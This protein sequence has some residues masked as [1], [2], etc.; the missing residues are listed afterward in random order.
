MRPASLR[1]VLVALVLATSTAASADVLELV[2]G[3]VVAGK[4]DAIDEDGVTFVPEKGGSMRVRWDRVPHQTRYDLTRATLAADDAQGRV[5][6]ARWCASVGLYRAARREL[7]EAKGLGSPEGTDV[8]ALLAEVR[9]AEADATLEAVDALADRGDL[10]V[11]L[12][13]LK[14]Y[15]RSADP[16]PDAD[17]VRSRVADVLQRIERRDEEARQGEE[18]RKKA[19]KDGRLKDWIARTMKGADE[20]KEDAGEAA[21]EAF[22]HLAKG[23]QSRARDALAASEKK[24]QAARADYA[25]VR[26]AVKEGEAADEC[27]ER[28]KDC[29]ERT[30]EV[31]V[32]WGRLEVQNK[33]WK[34]ASSIV[35]RGLKIDAVDRELLELRAT[36]DANWV[37]RKLSDVSN[38][39]GHSSSN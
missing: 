10:D 20:K 4:V 38:A 18:E 17:R 32:R 15:L 6:L 27:A 9:S 11:A 1:A 31:L 37:R 39:R 5:K 35:D 25:R 8:D 14:S 33:S 24:Y 26:K 2:T 19:E 21:A 7:V 16:G 28:A 34:Q 12:D 30:V 36:I 22:T 3:E 13:R 29:D 23:S